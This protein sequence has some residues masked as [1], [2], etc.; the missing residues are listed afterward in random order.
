MRT[1]AKLP[2]PCLVDANLAD[3]SDLREDVI[4]HLAANPP[5]LP[6]YDAE[7]KSLNELVLVG[8]LLAGT[9]LSLPTPEDSKKRV[10]LTAVRL[11][12]RRSC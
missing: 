2:A 1:R 12:M 11:L 4:N 3:A 5:Q 10:R 7:T 8:L 9:G 6:A